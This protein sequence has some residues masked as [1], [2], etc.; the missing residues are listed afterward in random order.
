MNTH[1][2]V[3]SFSGKMVR[4]YVRKTKHQSWSEVSIDAVRQGLLKY[5]RAAVQFN[6]P[7]ATLF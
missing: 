7:A 5:K 6:V 4:K 2:I 3:F 1:N